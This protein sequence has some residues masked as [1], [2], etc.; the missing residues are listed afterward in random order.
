[1]T[2]YQSIKDFFYFS[3]S[4]TCLRNIGLITWVGRFQN[5]ST[6]WYYNAQN[7]WQKNLLVFFVDEITTIDI[8]SWFSI[9]GYVFKNW[10]QMFL[11]LNLERIINDVFF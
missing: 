6:I 8:K 11:L 5:V 3:K 9:H 2:Y 1:M 7:R 10:Q 4:T